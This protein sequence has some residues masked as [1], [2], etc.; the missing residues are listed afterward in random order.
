[1]CVCVNVCVYHPVPVCVHN[2]NNIIL[3]DIIIQCMPGSCLKKA[4]NL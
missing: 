3:Y 1:M 4:C 2:F